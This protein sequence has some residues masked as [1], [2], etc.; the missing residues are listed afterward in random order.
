MF[1]SKTKESLQFVE[2]FAGRGFWRRKWAGGSRC[3]EIAGQVLGDAPALEG[4]FDGFALGIV[5][6]EE[7]ARNKLWTKL[8][9]AG[10]DAASYG[11][12]SGCALGF[13]GKLD[14]RFEGLDH[15]AERGGPR[16]DGML[17]LKAGDEPVAIDGGVERDNLAAFELD[18]NAGEDLAEVGNERRGW[19]GAG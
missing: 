17:G 6:V 7:N 18:G 16:D 19:A 10:C 4:E 1:G 8:T 13:G 5:K 3:A 9:G 14:L 11:W 12:P 2:C 15:I